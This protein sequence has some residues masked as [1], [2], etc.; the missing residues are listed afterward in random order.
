MA[1]QLKTANMITITEALQEIKTV[2]NR[3]KKK[4]VAIGTYLARD[5]RVI[6]PLASDGGSEKYITQERQSITDLETRIINIR[7]A[8]QNSNLSS[9]LTVGDKTRKVAEWLVWRREVAEDSRA[10]LVSLTNG[11]NN[12][13]N[14][15]QKKGGRLVGAAVAINEGNN[16]NDPPQMIVNVNEKE[17]LNEQENMEQVLGELDGKLSLFNATTTIEL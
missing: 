9:S 3:L 14:E 1:K 8:I 11:I 15:L 16:A 5:K 13:R 6:D 10:F 2:G 17:L 12:L 4:R 7:T